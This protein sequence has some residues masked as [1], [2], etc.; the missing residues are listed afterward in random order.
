[1]E[2][3]VG[4]AKGTDYYKSTGD[5]L[6]VSI[7]ALTRAEGN[8]EVYRTGDLRSTAGSDL[9]QTFFEVSRIGPDRDFRT[10][11]KTNL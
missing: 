1:M 9:C 7:Y 11:T 8:L 6:G 5:S 3:S 2:W 10:L 4:L